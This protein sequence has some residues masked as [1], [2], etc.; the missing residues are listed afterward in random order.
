MQSFNGR[1][2]KH[3]CR[4]LTP[5]QWNAFDNELE[6][7]LDN[8]ESLENKDSELLDNFFIEP[9]IEVKVQK[10]SLSLKYLCKCLASSC[11]NEVDSCGKI[12]N[13]ALA[14]ECLIVFGQE[15]S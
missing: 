4:S 11:D 10:L 15:V 14:L 12:D 8:L 1:K 13:L 3:T 7:C 2:I 9:R 5:E 6:K